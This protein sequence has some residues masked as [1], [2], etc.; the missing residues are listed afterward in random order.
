MSMDG[1]RRKARAADSNVTSIE[2]DLEAAIGIMR[3][4]RLRTGARQYCLAFE[5]GL[6]LCA[7]AYESAAIPMAS[8]LWILAGL[9]TPYRTP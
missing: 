4:D 8:L 5:L 3:I 2:G 7:C 9:S 6:Q 1:P